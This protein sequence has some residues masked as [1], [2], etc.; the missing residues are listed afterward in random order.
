MFWISDEYLRLLIEEDL[1]I[2]DLTS[3]ALKLETK[4]GI[5]TAA[6]KK[7][8]V[9]AGVEEAARLLKLCGVEAVALAPNGAAVTAGDL[10]LKAEGPADRLHAA[11]KTAQN[12]MEHSS[13]IASRCAALVRLARQAA[14]QVEISVT[15]KHFPGTKRLS[16]AAALAGGASIHRLGLSDSILVFDQHRV[17]VGGVKGFAGLVAELS[18]AFRKKRSPPKSTIRP[19]RRRWRRPAS[20]SSNANALTR[21]TSNGP[22]SPSRPSTP[23]R[24]CWPPAGSP[25][26]TSSGWPPRAWTPW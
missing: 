17:F 4:R 21:R 10:L 9:A 8:C 26:P 15:R 23:G 20:T 6:P 16:L 11:A 13:G 22:W 18:A 12:V 1:H 25:T 19:R 7:S 2:L 24:S 14:P 5:L 3:A